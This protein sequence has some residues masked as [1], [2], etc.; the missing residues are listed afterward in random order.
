MPLFSSFSLHG[1]LE[2]AKAEM[3]DVQGG[4]PGEELGLRQKK[5]TCL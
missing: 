4:I 1:E 2:E 5:H 3:C